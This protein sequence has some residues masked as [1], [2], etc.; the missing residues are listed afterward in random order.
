M[1]SIGIIRK[2][3]DTFAHKPT[4]SWDEAVGGGGYNALTAGDVCNEGND[5]EFLKKKQ[6]LKRVI[7]YV[8]AV[9]ACNK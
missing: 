6:N 5:F 9:K 8:F 7:S 4:D 2:V 3:I 1:I